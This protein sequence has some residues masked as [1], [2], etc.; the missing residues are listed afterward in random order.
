[1]RGRKTNRLMPNLAEQRIISTEKNLNERTNE[2]RTRITSIKF[3][4]M[5][6]QH[7]FAYRVIIAMATRLVINILAQS[8]EYLN[9]SQTRPSPSESLLGT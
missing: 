2:T 4:T 5:G 3:D 1:M 7:G 8:S 9:T 6:F